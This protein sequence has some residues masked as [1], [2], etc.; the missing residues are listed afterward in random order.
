MVARQRLRYVGL[1][2]ERLEVTPQ[3]LRTEH[4]APAEQRLVREFQTRI[5]GVVGETGA[6]FTAFNLL[7]LV[8][9]VADAQARQCE[10]R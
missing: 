4:T 6:D 10:A 3:G 1:F 9:A 8:V 2:A 5:G 7:V